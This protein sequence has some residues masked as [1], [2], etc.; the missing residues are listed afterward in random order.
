M[1]VHASLPDDYP[2]LDNSVFVVIVIISSRIESKVVPEYI[3]GAKPESGLDRHKIKDED[4][5]RNHDEYG[6]I[7]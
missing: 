7:S 3:S 4:W 1:Y 5:D 2:E 6:V